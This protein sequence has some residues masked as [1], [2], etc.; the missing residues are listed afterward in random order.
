MNILG[1]NHFF[2]DTSVC[3]VSDGKL[4]A[5]LEE[6]RFS[7]QKHTTAFPVQAAKRCMQLGGLEPGQVDHIAVSVEPKHKWEAKLAYAARYPR[8]AKTFL[9]AETRRLWSRKRSLD[10]WMRETWPD[11]SRR[12]QLHYVQHHVA[13]VGGS[14]LVSGFEE[15][16]LLG[17]DGS[18]EWAT[19]LLGHG[20]GSHI[21][22]FQQSWFPMSLGSYYEAITD[23]TGFQPNYDEGKTMGLAPYGD[24]EPYYERVRELVRVNEDGSIA[25][26]LSYFNH[27]FH[28][29][30]RYSDKFVDTFGT[31]RRRDKNAPFEEH[32]KNVAASFQKVLED[33]ALEMCQILHARTKAS[34]L[35]LA[36]GVALNSVMNGRIARESPFDDLYVMPGAGDN[37]TCIGAAYYVYNTVLGQPRNFV[38]DDPYVGTE[39]SDEEIRAVIERCGLP[40]ER[41]DDIESVAAELLVK[42][43][44]LGWFQHRMEFGPRSLGAR[45]ILANPMLPDMKAVLNARVKHREPFRPFAPSCPSERM[46]EFFDSTVDTPFMLKVCNVHL[47]KRESLPAIT[48][49]D[50]SARLQTVHA[51]LHPR[52]HKLLTEFGA[53]TGVPVLLNTSFNIMGEPII[54]HPIQAVR[55]FFS[56]G[57]DELILGNYVIRKPTAATSEK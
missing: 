57:L 37:G 6:E 34:K 24:P 32:H 20:R 18:G 15:A 38:H 22:L 43:R 3:L 47:E 10:R 1:I 2:H 14:F 4:V 41:Y 36:G 17:I 26:D 49:V 25:L 44:M 50:G 52:Y 12:P 33:C 23:W 54:E 13:H 51:D 30:R 9:R 29:Y 21:E 35:V 48:H 19:S 11:A 55:C 8:H 31:P 46:S 16:A 42:G 39:Y 28:A 7:R 27:Q 5:A 56:T 45:S 40:I 53:R